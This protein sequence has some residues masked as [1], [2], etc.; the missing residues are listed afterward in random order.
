MRFKSYFTPLPDSCWLLFGPLEFIGLSG[1]NG[2]K[3]L[4]VFGKVDRPLYV[5]QV[6]DCFMFHVSLCEDVNITLLGAPLLGLFSS[7]DTRNS[8][9]VEY[10]C[11]PVAYGQVTLCIWSLL[12][13]SFMSFL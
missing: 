2:P 6:I 12:L 3:V 13:R 8:F 9:P 7:L 11:C 5:S 10:C 1:A 4:T